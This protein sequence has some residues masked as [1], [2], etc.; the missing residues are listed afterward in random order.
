MDAAELA[1]V[2]VRRRDHRFEL[3]AAARMPLGPGL[4][5]PAFEGRNVPLPDEL[6]TAMDATARTAGLGRR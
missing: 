3:A 4:L 6:A 1:A 2:E 5:T